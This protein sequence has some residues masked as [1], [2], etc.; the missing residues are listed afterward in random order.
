MEV[1]AAHDFFG[2]GGGV[3]RQDLAYPVAKLIGVYPLSSSERS[4]CFTLTR[5]D[6]NLEYIYTQRSNPIKAFISL[7]F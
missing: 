4:H 3:V 6:L 2:V 5:V 1:A 7:Q